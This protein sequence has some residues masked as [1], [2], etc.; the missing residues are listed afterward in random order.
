M[1][2]AKIWPQ[3]L[4]LE[5]Y[6]KLKENNRINKIKYSNDPDK[7]KRIDF[8]EHIINNADIIGYKDSTPTYDLFGNP[9]D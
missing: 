1:P 6:D 9:I 8:Y 3:T 2:A 4:T 5:L 7:L